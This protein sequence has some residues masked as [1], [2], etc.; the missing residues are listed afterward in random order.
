MIEIDG[1]NY[2]VSVTSVGLDAE[3]LYKYATRTENFDL[4][5]ELG[6]VYY[7]QTLTFGCEDSD[8]QDFVDLYKLLS[9]KSKI[10]KGTGHNVKI[11]TPMGQL[12]FLMYPNKITVKMLKQRD[13]KTWWSDMQVKFI[14]IKPVERW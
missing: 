5:Y 2:N 11:W 8:N 10:D 1:K 4:N 14:M 7:N 9:T 13:N 3:F 12:T 6:A